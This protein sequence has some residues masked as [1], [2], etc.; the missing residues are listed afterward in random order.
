MQREHQDKQMWTE[1]PSGARELED[2]EETIPEHLQCKPC[3]T[4]ETCF[5]AVRK[6]PGPRLEGAFGH[7]DS[8]VAGRLLLLISSKD[9]ALGLSLLGVSDHTGQH[10]SSLLSKATRTL[11]TQ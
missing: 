6:S 7:W 11:K 5:S 1:N 10:I 2:K 4:S 9:A 3:W 8:Y